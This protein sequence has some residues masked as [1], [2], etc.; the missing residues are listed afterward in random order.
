MAWFLNSYR[1]DRC[2]KEWQDDWSCGCDDE[3]PHCGARHMSP[4]NSEDLTYYVEVGS[5]GSTFEVYES[6]LSAEHEPDY[7]MIAVTTSKEAAE[8][9]IGRR[10][11]TYWDAILRP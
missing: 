7:K 8:D 3:C 1:C 2:G 5:G 9:Y 4:Y 11:T 6:P 10:M